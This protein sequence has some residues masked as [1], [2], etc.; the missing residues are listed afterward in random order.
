VRPRG[1]RSTAALAEYASLVK[2]AACAPRKATSVLLAIARGYWYRA[3]CRVR[4]IRFEAGRNL[5]VFGR[6]SFKGPGLVRFGDNVVV[7]MTVTP[8]TYHADASIEIG[9]GT[10]LNGTQFGCTRKI[11]IGAESTVGNAAIMDTNFHSTSINRRDPA[12]PVKSEPVHIGSNVWIGAQA[13]ILPGTR[14]GDNSV[15]GFGAV[16]V[17]KYPAN[18]LIGPPRA[19]VLRELA[20]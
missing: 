2:A 12:A 7:D 13:G 3:T 20:P 10:F 11:S 5:R 19:T 16:C 14:I 8:W 17:G 6:L 18:M 15:V 9:D 1:G 4:G